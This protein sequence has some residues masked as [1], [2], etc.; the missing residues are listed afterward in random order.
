MGYE[1]KASLVLL[2]VVV[3]VGDAYPMTSLDNHHFL[4]GEGQGGKGGLL[5]QS[6]GCGCGDIQSCRASNEAMYISLQL[7]GSSV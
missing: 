1:C 7:V 6:L 3:V 4:C 5:T 2:L